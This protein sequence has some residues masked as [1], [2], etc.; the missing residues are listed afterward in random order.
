[1]DHE[2]KIDQVFSKACRRWCWTCFDPAV[3]SKR[4]ALV[5]NDPVG[6]AIWQYEKSP[7]TG[8]LHIQ[9][10]TRFNR[11][12]R[13]SQLQKII[14][15]P[16][17][18]IETCKGSEDKNL[19]YCSKTESRIEGPWEY[20]SRAKPGKRTDLMDLA[21]SIK[22]KGLDAAIEE[23][24]DYYIR[25]HGGMEKYAARLQPK[26]QVQFAE[27]VVMVITGPAGSGKS[28][29]AIEYTPTSFYKLP[30]P[31]L[32]GTTWFSGYTGQTTLILD[33]YR[34]WLDYAM[35]LELL[36]G[37]QGMYQTKGGFIWRNWN[38]VIITTNQNWY[39]WH[40]RED[41][42]PLQRR[43]TK[44]IKHEAGQWITYD[45]KPNPRGAGNTKPP[46]KLSELVKKSSGLFI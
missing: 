35:L 34:G 23:R 39:E 30:K 19:A 42:E 40:P 12:V 8:R 43:I 22:D 44:W 4:A 18:H 38:T 1:M 29:M 10:Y 13:A 33:E 46:P 2:E 9:G 25:Y 24:P 41:K 21:E 16:K 17:L 11:P 28:R 3:I 31:T 37:Y 32:N 27:P 7:K 20:G 6:F 14:G 26:Q 5:F 36:D 45:R 15:D